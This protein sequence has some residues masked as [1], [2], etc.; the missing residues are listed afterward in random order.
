MLLRDRPWAWC[1]ASLR[2]T[3][4]R[5]RAQAMR[6]RAQKAVLE[7]RRAV[8]GGDAAGGNAAG[9]A[10]GGGAR[11][12]AAADAPL[13]AALTGILQLCD[14]AV[15]ARLAPPPPPAGL[16]LSRA[17]QSRLLLTVLPASRGGAALTKPLQIRGRASCLGVGHDPDPA[18]RS[19]ARAGQGPC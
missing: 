15:E 11:A 7:A 17:M 3:A 14:A 16:A 18:L 13:R 12:A 9:G 19:S 6:W 8:A 10:E 5:A 4:T 2:C 1:R